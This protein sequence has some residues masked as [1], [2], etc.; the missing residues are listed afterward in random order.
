[1]EALGDRQLC[2][3]PLLLQLLLLTPLELRQQL[4]A[5]AHVQQGAASWCC[6][7]VIR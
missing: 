2:A 5:Q 4:R 1:M 3:L 7:S 6:L